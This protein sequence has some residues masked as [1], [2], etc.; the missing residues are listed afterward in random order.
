MTHKEN[1]TLTRS[2]IKMSLPQFKKET[3][4]STFQA[5]QP[6][7]KKAAKQSLDILIQSS[8]K[9]IENTKLEKNNIVQEFGDPRIRRHSRIC[10]QICDKYYS[11]LEIRAIITNAGGIWH[12]NR[13]VINQNC[14]L[15]IDQTNFFTLRQKLKKEQ[16]LKEKLAK[17]SKMMVPYSRMSQ[18]LQA[19]KKKIRGIPKIHNGPQNTPPPIRDQKPPRQQKLS[20]KKRWKSRKKAAKSRKED[21]KGHSTSAKRA[22]NSYRK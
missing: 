11:R 17:A 19:V 22:G 7:A 2:I 14:P 15:R 8:K 20:P 5:A 1:S 10:Y 18:R 21:A 9:K 16:F 6:V 3:D 13:K 4:Y 12:Q